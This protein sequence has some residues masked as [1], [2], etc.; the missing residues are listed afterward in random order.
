MDEVDIII[1]NNFYFDWG[2]EMFIGYLY[3]YL[4]FGWEKFNFK[5]EK[6]DNK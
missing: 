1:N 3:Y 5:K 2:L 4:D 6:M